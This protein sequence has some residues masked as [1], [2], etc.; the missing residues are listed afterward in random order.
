LSDS[1][2]RNGP[3][4]IT[5]YGTSYIRGTN[6]NNVVVVGAYGEV[7]H[8]NGFS[9]KSFLPELGTLQ[10]SYGSVDIKNNIVAITGYDGRKAKITI[11]RA[12]K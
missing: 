4:D 9:W 6:L 1:N 8:F 10:G 11:A 2:W 7:L 3:L 12:Q 5:Q